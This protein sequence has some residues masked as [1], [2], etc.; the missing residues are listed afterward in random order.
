[1]GSL[2]LIFYLQTPQTASSAEEPLWW[3]LSLWF[4]TR[5][6]RVQLGL[7]LCSW[8]EER[9]IKSSL[10]GCIFLNERHTVTF[11]Q[12][13]SLQVP[14]VQLPTLIWHCSKTLV[15]ECLI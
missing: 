10:C 14:F 3:G 2:T 7:C 15:R 9:L 5:M 12:C 11:Q 13:K 6:L 8:K 1:M 4:H